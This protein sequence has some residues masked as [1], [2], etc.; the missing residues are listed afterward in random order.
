M[1]LRLDF[2]SCAL[3]SA[4][5]SSSHDTFVSSAVTSTSRSLPGTAT[6]T[7]S[8]LSRTATSTSGSL[9]RAATST[10]GSLSRAATSTSIPCAATSTSCSLPHPPT[11]M[12]SHAT[13][14][15]VP[16]TSNV[17]VSSFV[18]HTNTGPS[19]VFAS[20]SSSSAS[21]ASSSSSVCASSTFTYSRSGNYYRLKREREQEGTC[22]TKKAR[23]IKCV[24]CN[25]LTQGHNKYQRKTYCP[26]SKKSTSVGL[27]DTY[28]TFEDFKKAVDEL[29][30]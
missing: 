22:E 7:S 14:I 18:T 1:K 10:S 30:K 21:C 27:P 25:E 24:L 12:P 23:V 6:S 26:N 28:E 17:S 2:E 9:S 15:V 4:P 16:S 8:S 19:S 13:T 3:T 29:K 11:T 5:S 20:S